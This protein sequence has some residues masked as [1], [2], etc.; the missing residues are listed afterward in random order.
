MMLAAAVEAEIDR[1]ERP[2]A[3]LQQLFRRVFPSEG[4]FLGLSPLAVGSSPS[5][6]LPEPH[7]QRRP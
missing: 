6:S 3:A 5:R 7:T 1:L 4:V 2:A